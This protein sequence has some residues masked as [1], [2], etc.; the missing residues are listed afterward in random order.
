METTIYR[1]C[2]Q[3]RIDLQHCIITYKRIPCIP[4]I[5]GTYTKTSILA[6]H[7]NYKTY[8]LEY[9]LCMEKYLLIKT[10]QFPPN[11]KHYLQSFTTYL[12]S[13]IWHM[14]QDYLHTFIPLEIQDFL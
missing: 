8:T 5:L 9:P 1:F 12:P 7:T 13:V 14:I 2:L 3:H 10:L 6:S 4:Y 11:R